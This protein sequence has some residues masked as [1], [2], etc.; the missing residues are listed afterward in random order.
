MISN[1]DAFDE[2]FLLKKIKFG[3]AH[4]EE[5]KPIA[6]DQRIDDS[7]FADLLTGRDKRDRNAEDAEWEGYSWIARTTLK[8]L[9]YIK[10]QVLSI[11]NAIDTKFFAAW[12]LRSAT[13]KIH[14]TVRIF[15][16]PLKTRVFHCLYTSFLT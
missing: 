1:N 3:A 5:P 9:W 11:Y 14:I 15:F 10:R 4:K 6:F 13:I 12:F 7:D 8:P 16:F 2:D